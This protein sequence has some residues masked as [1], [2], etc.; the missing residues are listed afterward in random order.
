MIAR[1]AAFALPIFTILAAPALAADEPPVV[2]A[3]FKAWETQYKVKPTYKNLTTDGDT[4]TIEG[5]EAA[6]PPADGSSGGSSAKLAIAKF[7]LSEVSDEGNGVFEI[8]TA[9]FSDLKVEFGN[10][11]DGLSI[12]IPTGTSEDW[13]V[14][15]LGD[16][17]A[18]SDVFRASMNIARKSTSGQITLTAAGQSVTADGYEVTWD[19][20]V[21]TGAGKSTFKISNI[22]IPEPVVAKVDPVGTLKQIGYTTLSFDL[23]G[24]GKFDVA[25]DKIGFDFDIYYAGKDMG[26]MKVGAAAGDIPMALMSE[27]QKDQPSDF[28]KLMPM[29]QG[30]QMS[31]LLFRFEDQSI[32]KR[33]LPLAAKMQGMDEQTFVA[34][35]GAMVQL[36]L[37]TLKNPAF[38]EKVVAAVNA[39]LKDPRSITLTAKPAQPVTVMQVMSL[40]PANPGAAIDQ[41]GVS[42]SAND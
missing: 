31:R 4:I 8:D 17:P 32:T 23:G 5:I 39:Y 22:A 26:T 35:A 27:L 25:S 16:N 10:P 6:A 2:Q 14:K 37:A 33:L 24:E 15:A 18:P 36:G 40:D 19:G 13:Y 9:A 21:Q 38:T 41:L 11:N 20:D 42:V 12:A 1:R 7:E 29:V 34:S 28:A 3:I 30:I